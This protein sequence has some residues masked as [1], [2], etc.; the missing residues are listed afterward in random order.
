MGFFKNLG[1]KMSAITL[2][3]MEAAEKKKKVRQEYACKVHNILN[4]DAPPWTAQPPP[5]L[6][7]LLGIHE[8]DEEAQD[9]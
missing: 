4:P 5:P 8:E 1:R 9:E 3:G 6:D 7:E 2:A